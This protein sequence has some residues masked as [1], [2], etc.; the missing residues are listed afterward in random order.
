MIKE[1]QIS[2][3]LI[4]ICDVCELGYLDKETAEKCKEWCNNNGTCSLEN[5]Q[6]ARKMK[7]AD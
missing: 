3:K 6:H 7:S 5:N 1:K 4:L 2:D